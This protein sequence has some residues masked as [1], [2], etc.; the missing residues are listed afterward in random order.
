MATKTISQETK[1]AI[2][3]EVVINQ[4]SVAA[5]AAAYDVSPTTIRRYKAALESQV[6]DEHAKSVAAAEE[7]AKAKDV[8]AKKEVPM[9]KHRVSGYDIP[10]TKRGGRPRNGRSAM[11]YSAIGKFGITAPTDQLYNEVNR[12]SV[13][14]GLAILNKSTFS[15]MLSEFK[16]N[17]KKKSPSASASASQAT[18]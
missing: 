6:I 10:M 14:A 13:E 12:L 11:I 15:A 7:A 4:K 8:N 1:F 9:M 5:V 18:H 2:V 3:H 16:A 17:M